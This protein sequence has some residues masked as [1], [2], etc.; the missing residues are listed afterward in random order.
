MGYS[1]PYFAQAVL[2]R[3][4]VP[5]GPVRLAEA[6]VLRW[7]ADLFYGEHTQFGK[8]ATMAAVEEGVADELPQ[9]QCSFHPKSITDGWAICNPQWQ[10]ERIR[11]WIAEW[12]PAS[13]S[14][15]GTPDMIFDGLIDVPTLRVSNDALIVDYACMARAEKLLML[16]EGNT[17]SSVFH[18]KIW[19]DELGFDNATGIQTTRAWGVAGPPRGTSISSSWTGRPGGGVIVGE[20]GA[21]GADMYLSAGRVTN[22]F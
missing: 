3:I 15:V 21:G 16:Q 1:D 13:G 18:K 2:L 5:G 9:W 22:A 6:G 10:G 11:C 14:V 19:P 8:I 20:A 17:L 12:N 4:D 7:G